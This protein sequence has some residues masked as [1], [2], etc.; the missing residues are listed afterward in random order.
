MI[1]KVVPIIPASEAKKLWVYYY[2]SPWSDRG[3]FGDMFGAV[4]ALFSGLAFTG[5]IIALVFQRRELELQRIELE[6]TR[7]ELKRTAEAQEGSQGA[8]IE[9]ARMLKTT[10]EI[11]GLGAAITGLIA[12][13]TLFGPSNDTSHIKMDI[14]KYIGRLEQRLEILRQ[15]EEESQ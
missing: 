11:S 2:I 12:N 6:L 9:Q 13:R 1:A 7:K 4:N 14:K 15:S 5:V 3:Q 10:A 8:L